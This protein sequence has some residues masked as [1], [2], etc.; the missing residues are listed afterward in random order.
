MFL[1]IVNLNKSYQGKEILKDINLRINRGELISIVGPSGAGKTTLL[2]IIC[3]IESP[4]SGE[5]IRKDTF[6]WKSQPILVF[7]DYVLFPNMTVFE[8]IAFGL[9]ARK[10]GNR[11]IKQRVDDIM[12]FF[13]ISALSRQYPS[14]VSAGE[15]Q[16]IAIARALVLNPPMILLD[17]PFANLDKNLKFETAE[18]I[19]S[20]QKEFGITSVSVTHDLKEAFM[21]S[22]RIGVMIKGEIVQYDTP[23][24]IYKSPAAVDVAALLGDINIL[25]AS[26]V[27]DICSSYDSVNGAK[28]CVR[29]ESVK[30][31]KSEH[32]EGIIVNAVFAGHYTIVTVKYRGIELRSFNTNGSFIEGEKVKITIDQIIQFKE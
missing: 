20:T 26:L 27:K 25:P 13:K 15:K 5:V 18:F 7:Q 8:N 21:I 19:R 1:E 9:K 29:P 12:N 23:A 28:V 11:I 22:D 32:S 14:Q 16:R 3:G 17:E 31:E 10:I 24:E 30:L 6:N 2:K 4:D